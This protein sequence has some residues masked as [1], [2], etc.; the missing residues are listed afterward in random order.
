MHAAPPP[1]PRYP[2][3]A[4]HSAGYG[5]PRVNGASLIGA[6]VGGLLGAQ[7]GGGSGQLAA[8]AAGTLGGFLIGDRMHD[9]Y[10]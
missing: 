4:P 8:T 1:E 10:R 9:V 2:Q 3:P 7:I 5:H 6:A